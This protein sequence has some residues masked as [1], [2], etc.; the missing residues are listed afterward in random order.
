M[1]SS[2]G[3]TRCMSYHASLFIVTQSI[4]GWWLSCL[5]CIIVFLSLFRPVLGEWPPRVLAVFFWIHLSYM[6]SDCHSGG[7]EEFFLRWYNAVWSLK[8]DQYIEGTWRGALFCVLLLVPCV[9]YLPTVKIEAI[10][11]SETLLDFQWTMRRYITE[12]RRT[13]HQS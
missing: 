7:Y 6:I 13:L 2:S 3:Y 11:S 4:W 10:C 5:R 9:A 8:V 1:Y 12:D